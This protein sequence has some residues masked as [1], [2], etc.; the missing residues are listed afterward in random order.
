LIDELVETKLRRRESFESH[1]T[2]INWI[3]DRLHG[4]HQSALDSLIKSV[5]DKKMLLIDSALVKVLCANLEQEVLDV[6]KQN[7][8][9][10]DDETLKKSTQL[11]SILKKRHVSQSQTSSDCSK[12]YKQVMLL[13][14]HLVAAGE[15]QK[16]LPEIG[17]LHRF[18]MLQPFNPLTSLFFKPVLEIARFVSANILYRIDQCNAGK[19]EFV[20]IDGM[21][22]IDLMENNVKLNEWP[23]CKL[24]ITQICEPGTTERYT[25]ATV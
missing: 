23:K 4:N 22:L 10:T 3:V 12:L 8:A 19:D 21:S 11:I 25:P 2:R 5:P 18:V 16:S 17:S 14:M 20:L 6:F 1:N 24:L 13:F 9:Q 15:K 7:I